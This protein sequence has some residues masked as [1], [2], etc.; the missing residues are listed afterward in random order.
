M[1]LGIRTWSPGCSLHAPKPLASP[2]KMMTEHLSL[3]MAQ[4]LQKLFMVAQHV[5]CL[6]STC[7][8]G[9]VHSGDA[10][11]ALGYAFPEPQ[12]QELSTV[13]APPLQPPQES[14][15]APLSPFSLDTVPPQRWHLSNSHV[16]LGRTSYP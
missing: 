14:H 15:R 3:Q 12:L 2:V 4:E 8:S 10:S 6:I 13:A 5:P 9:A 11:P 1:V 7:P 16:Q